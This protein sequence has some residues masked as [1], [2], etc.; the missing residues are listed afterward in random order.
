MRHRLYLACVFVS[1]AAC[2]SAC[3]E[4]LSSIAGPTPTL[5]PT[6]TSI[7]RDIFE[8]T[9]SSGRSA[10]VSCHTSTGRAPSGGLDLNHDV[11][12]GQLVNALVREKPGSTRVVPSDAANSY[13][14]QKLNGAAG[15]VGRRMPQN[16]PPYLTDGQILIIQ[17]WI[18]TGAPNN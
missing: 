16:G 3:D 10:C 2:L 8:A 13:L 7:Q 15:I 14:L 17:R 12:Y 1:G 4:P 5:E 6:F 18:D 11:A 9:D